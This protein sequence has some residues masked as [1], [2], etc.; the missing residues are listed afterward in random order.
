MAKLRQQREEEAEAR[1]QQRRMEQKPAP[2]S[3]SEST[4]W[5]KPGMSTTFASSSRQAAATTSASG[6]SSEKYRP[7]Q[8]RSGMSGG[9][10]DRA[11]AK[12][13]GVS[14]PPRTASPAVDPP[15]S[16]VDKDGYQTVPAKA[17]W[18]RRGQ[19]N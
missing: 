6:A 19:G 2:P 15:K 8:L 1:R 10:R 9:W 17:V 3:H 7:G 11:A 13:E 4:E 16:S 12:E 5:R 14:T 18:R